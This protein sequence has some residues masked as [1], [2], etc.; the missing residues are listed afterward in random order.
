VNKEASHY[1]GLFG[2]NKIGTL[3]FTSTCIFAKHAIFETSTLFEGA[4]LVYSP[5]L[6][7]EMKGKY[8]C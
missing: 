6:L 3:F 2:G 8:T 7:P 5:R 4:L 1:V